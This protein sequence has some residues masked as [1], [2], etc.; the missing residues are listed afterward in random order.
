MHLQSFGW[1]SIRVRL[2]LLFSLT[3]LGVMG[4]ALSDAWSSW[5]TLQRLQQMQALEQSAQRIS[6]VVHSLQKERGLSAGWIGAQGKRFASELASQRDATDAAHQVLRRYLAEQ[7][8]QVLG[9]AA[10]SALG[11][12]DR[13]LNA[14]LGAR[15]GISALT[16]SAPTSFGQYTATIDAYL[17]VLAQMPAQAS[18]VTLTRELSA[19]VRFVNAKEQ[20]GRERATINAITTA[21]SALD[22]ALYRRLLGILTTQEL[23]LRQFQEQ[24]SPASRQALEALLATPAAQDTAALRK[25]VLERVHQGGFA[26]APDQWFATITRKIDA[27]KALEDQLADGIHQQVL[28]LGDQARWRVGLSLAANLTMLLLG[29]LFGLLVN[30]VLAAIHRTADVA[31][32]LAQGDLTATVEVEARDELGE[33]QSS[34]QYTLQ[35]L[36]Q[37]IGEIRAASDQ[38]SNAADQVSTTSQSLAQ[39]ASTQA[40]SVEETSSA[41]EQMSAAI[42]HNADSARHTD[43]LAAQAASEAQAG[44]QAVASTVEAMRQIAEKIRIIDDITYQTNLLA[45]NAAIEAARAGSHGKGFA[46]VASEVRKLAE[47]SQ[48]A[49]QDI[50]QLASSSVKQAEQ[51]GQL[52]EK[53]V[54]AISQTSVQVQ[55]IAQSSAEQATGVEQINRAMGLL[56]QSTQHTASASEQLAATA[57]QMG[58]QAQLLQESMAHFRLQKP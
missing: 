14:V 8:Q 39:S 31:R 17:A 49:A 32:Q 42:D 34:L 21:D 9:A 44:E 12:A 5:H 50:G 1:R 46:V 6:A 13:Q 36:A 58:A 16:V 57:E 19:Y 10:L 37:M 30:R 25:R 7:D 54:P 41:M 22:D 45:L 2:Y 3:L 18:D 15:A 38:L 56:N 43:G 47:R 26:I 27:M 52:L 23:F 20:A 51:A 4:Y 53:M 55:Q 40:A 33:L 48:L 28:S 11:E 29:L 35:H 24:A